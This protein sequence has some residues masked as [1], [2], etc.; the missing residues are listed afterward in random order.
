MEVRFRG[1]RIFLDSECVGA[2]LSR[3]AVGS[4][5]YGSVYP[6]I[7]DGR[8]GYVTKIIPIAEFRPEREDDSDYDEEEKVTTLEDVEHELVITAHAAN[9]GI[10][11]QVKRSD[12]CNGY[13]VIVMIALHTTLYKFFMTMRL[14]T[15]ANRITVRRLFN[16]LRDRAIKAGLRHGDLHQE[17]IMLTLFDDRVVGMYLIDFGMSE[18][19]HPTNVENEWRL[20]ITDE[21]MFESDERDFL[22]L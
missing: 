17:N 3:N 1:Q 18:I 19:T 15:D 10:G 4:G 22:G 7:I 20:F 2:Q 21:T 12:V 9:L 8:P 13:G 6:S 14:R 16:E 5:A 11:P